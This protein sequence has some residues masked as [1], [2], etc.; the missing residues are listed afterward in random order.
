MIGSFIIPV[1]DL[2]HELQE[3][4]RSETEA[5]EKVVEEI[6][7]MVNSEFLVNSYHAQLQIEKEAEEAKREEELEKVRVNK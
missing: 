5:L 4:R 6:K 7:K 1:G 2:M 3:N